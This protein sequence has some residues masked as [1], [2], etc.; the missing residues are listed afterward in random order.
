[1]LVPLSASA[2]CYLLHGIVGERRRQVMQ[3]PTTT[4]G[5]LLDIL[6]D[7]FVVVGVFTHIN[8]LTSVAGILS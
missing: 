7:E 6:E 8:D 1:M 5:Y 2:I 3:P 4:D